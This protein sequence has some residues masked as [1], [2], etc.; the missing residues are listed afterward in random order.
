LQKFRLYYSSLRDLRQVFDLVDDN[1][2]GVLQADELEN[3]FS[4]GNR[5]RGGDAS[6]S[7]GRSSMGRD[8]GGGHARGRTSMA[9]GAGAMYG[10]MF[11]R[12][13]KREMTFKDVLTVMYP[14]VRGALM[15][16][17]VSIN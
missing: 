9:A 8:S 1:G 3:Q 11:K 7:L 14:Q 5:G 13:G 6:S 17:P 4:E 16:I 12:R 15:F 2:D 10:Q